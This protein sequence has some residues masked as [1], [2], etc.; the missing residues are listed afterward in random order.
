MTEH[1]KQESRRAR[2]LAE[3]YSAKFSERVS[4]I[5]VDSRTAYPDQ[6]FLAD[7]IFVPRGIKFYDNN[8]RIK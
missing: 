6:I 1:M 4:L 3:D 8:V 2:F 7:R 5:T